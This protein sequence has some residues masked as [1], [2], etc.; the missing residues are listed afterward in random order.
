MPGAFKESLEQNQGKV[1]ILA[2]HLSS[3]QIGW[4]DEAQEDEKGLFVKGYLDIDNNQLARERM[5]LAKL[6]MKVGRKYGL[7]IGYYLDEYTVRPG[8]DGV[9]ATYELNKVDLKEYSLVAFPMNTQAMITAIKSSDDARSAAEWI[10]AQ[11]AEKQRDKII[12]KNLLD[13]QQTLDSILSVI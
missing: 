5:G 2:D 8:K 1:P 6:A 4:N 7:S 12:F 11:D 10:M 13:M 3:K 9:P